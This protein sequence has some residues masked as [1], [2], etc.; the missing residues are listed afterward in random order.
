VKIQV[1]HHRCGQCP[2][3]LADRNANQVAGQR[4][5]TTVMICSVFLAITGCRCPDCAAPEVRHFEM[6]GLTP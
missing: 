3:G 2:S 4:T 6:K 1:S 5:L